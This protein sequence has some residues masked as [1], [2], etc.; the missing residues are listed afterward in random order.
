ME[1]EWYGSEISPRLTLNE[2]E[3]VGTRSLRFEQYYANEYDL[4]QMLID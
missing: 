4:K 1:E 3:D 2:M